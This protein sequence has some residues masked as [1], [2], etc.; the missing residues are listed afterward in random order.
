MSVAPVEPGLVAAAD[1]ADI[2]ARIQ[3]RTLS[4]LVF[5]QT[6]AGT[7]IAIGVAVGALLAASLGGTRASGLA[8]SS[9][10]IGAALLAIP[11]TRIM[12]AGGR[13]PGLTFAYVAGA[14]GALMVVGGAQARSLGLVFAGMFLFGGASAA[15][16]QARYAAVDLAPPDRRARHLSLVVWAATVG[17]VAGPNLAPVA[18]DAALRWGVR[19][20]SGP[21]LFSALAFGVAAL[22]TFVL[23]RPD[24]LLAAR[25]AEKSADEAAAAPRRGGMWRGAWRAVRASPAAR[26][27]MSAVAVGHVV[28]VGVMSMTP[29][30]IGGYVH[31]HADQLR[32]VGLVISLHIVGMYALSPLVGWLTDRLGSRTVVLGA[33]GALLTACAVA[34]TARESTVRLSVGM[35]LL[36]VGWLGMMVAGSTLLSASV[37]TAQRTGAQGLSDVVMGVAGASAGAVAGVV[38][39]LF[40]Y[41]TLAL[42]AA[43]ATV[44]IL[45]L[46]LRRLPPPATA[47]GDGRLVQCG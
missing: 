19:D 32:V 31:Q 6:V 44:P 15:N 33:I 25:P 40:G 11:A 5:T 14:A 9:A 42:L 18:S 29:V 10:V 17:A 13:R 22:A 35:T 30:Y 1:G 8:G 26:L 47:S 43:I 16:L 45:A 2:K 3:R 46:A 39:D 37:E 21:Y 24:P 27:G 36:G 41:P 23:M 28:M 7:G 20:Y 4:V 12:R 34:G 38:V